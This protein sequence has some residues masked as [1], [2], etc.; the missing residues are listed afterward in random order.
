MSDT[1]KDDNNLALSDY[2]TL[3]NY[4]ASQPSVS[5]SPV[6]NDDDEDV[7]VV[8][9]FFCHACHLLNICLSLAPFFLS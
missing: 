2:A 8:C 4:G 9:S 7:V 1:G 3:L 6:G 5:S